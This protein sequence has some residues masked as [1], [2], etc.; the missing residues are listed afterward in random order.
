M[1]SHGKYLC[2][3]DHD[4]DNSFSSQSGDYESSS[5]Y[6]KLEESQNSPT[7]EVDIDNIINQSSS[8]LSNSLLHVLDGHDVAQISPQ[9]SFEKSRK[10]QLDE[11]SKDS[12]SSPDSI[13]KPLLD[14]AEND[15][16]DF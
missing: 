11:S 6:Q 3:E 5:E 1:Y 15:S 13:K 8:N 9:S 12:D 16:T 10:R 4:D 7:Q 14:T 2:D